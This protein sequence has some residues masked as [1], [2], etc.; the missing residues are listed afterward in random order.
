[1]TDVELSTFLEKLQQAVSAR[2]AK[3]IES[4]LSAE[5]M[6]SL[7]GDR[8]KTAFLEDWAVRQKSSSFWTYMDRILALGGAWEKGSTEGVP[9]YVFPYTY[10]VELDTEDDYFNIGIITGKN[11]NL[12]SQPDLNAEVVTQLSYHVVMFETDADGYR[13]HHGQNDHGDAEW[14]KVTTREKGQTGWVFWKYVYDL[15]GPR[16][17]LKPTGAGGWEIYAF[18]TGD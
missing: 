9:M 3:F 17:F 16:L 2:D 14:F 7:G 6:S 4:V 1:L 5:V 10:N 18:V 13:I 15:L 8:T 11:V 12:R